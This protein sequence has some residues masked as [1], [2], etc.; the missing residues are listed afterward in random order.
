VVGWLGREFFWTIPSRDSSVSNPLRPRLPRRL[1][2]DSLV[3]YTMPLSVSVDAGY[4]CRSPALR[5]V[6]STTGPVTRE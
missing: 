5:K 4:P 1:P 3:V 6:A 2:P